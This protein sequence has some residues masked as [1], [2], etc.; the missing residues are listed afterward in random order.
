MPSKRYVIYHAPVAHM[1]GKLTRDAV[2]VHNN[3]TGDT[4]PNS[5]YYGYRRQ[6]TPTRSRY[7][8][9]ERARNLLTNPYTA[10][11]LQ[12]VQTFT[13]SIASADIVLATPAKRAA[14]ELAYKD[15]KHGYTTLRGFIIAQCYKNGGQSPW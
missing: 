12:G 14:A 4:S 15:D 7:G 11:E 6:A 2:K 13:A 3:P 10:D 9:R 8:L 1:N 5:F